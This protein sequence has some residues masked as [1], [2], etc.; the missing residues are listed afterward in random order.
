[1]C[2]SAHVMHGS[3]NERCM[4]V[5]FMLFWKKKIQKIKDTAGTRTQ[6]PQHANP[7]RY[8]TEPRQ[9]TTIA[10]VAMEAHSCTK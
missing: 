9:P 2:M 5:M 10:Y 7:A 8:P 4:M 3:L 1:M 6:H